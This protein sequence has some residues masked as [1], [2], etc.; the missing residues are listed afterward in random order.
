MARF[1]VLVTLVVLLPW[2]PAFAG[3]APGD[4]LESNLAQL[5]GARVYYEQMLRDAKTETAA[6]YFIER[7]ESVRQRHAAL[8]E[9][10][11]AITP[12]AAPAPAAALTWRVDQWLRTRIHKKVS[13]KEVGLSDVAAWTRRELPDELLSSS[14]EWLGGKGPH[15]REAAEEAWEGRARAGWLSASYGSGT[16][17]VVPPKRR[18]PSKGRTGREP[19][20]VAPTPEPPTRDQW[21]AKASAAERTA[22]TLAFFVEN[23]GL[24][25]VSGERI[26]TGTGLKREVAVRYR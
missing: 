8:S 18:P 2:V 17:I 7:L 24:F 5:D 1:L 20:R 21:W 19:P 16:F 26:V 23:G 12:Q 9:A 4:D 13:E 22:W 3:E 10:L 11:A 15:T 25:D 6:K 14:A